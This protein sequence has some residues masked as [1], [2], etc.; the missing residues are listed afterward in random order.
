MFGHGFDG[1]PEFGAQGTVP[2]VRVPSI[3][4]AASVSADGSEA[5]S[6]PSGRPRGSGSG[7]TVSSKG[8]TVS[9]L[10]R[11][12]TWRSTRFRSFGHLPKIVRVNQQDNNGW[13]A[14]FYAVSRRDVALSRLLVQ[15]GASVALAD[16]Q[17]RTVLVNSCHYVLH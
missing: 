1:E 8:V 16:K 17:G 9:L 3:S 10:G 5:K 6:D 12:T 11:T 15:S 13:T 14:L 4:R 7:V 2:C